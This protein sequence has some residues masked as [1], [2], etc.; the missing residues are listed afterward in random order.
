MNMP[1]EIRVNRVTLGLLLFLAAQAVLGVIWG[2]RLD[3]NVASLS[4]QLS[5]VEASIAAGS[6]FRYTSADAGR[7]KELGIKLLEA[8]NRRIDLNETRIARLESG[9]ALP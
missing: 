2:A 7:D 1:E 3:A 8:M 5:K 9:K 4:I 6:Q